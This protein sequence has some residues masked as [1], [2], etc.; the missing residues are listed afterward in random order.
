MSCQAS[1]EVIVAGS[2]EMPRLLSFQRGLSVAGLV[3]AAA[4]V[5]GGVV[6]IVDVSACE[7]FDVLKDSAVRQQRTQCVPFSAS[8]GLLI[9]RW[10]RSV[11]SCIHGQRQ[12]IA[13]GFSRILQSLQN[14]ASIIAF[15]AFFPGPEVSFTPEK[16]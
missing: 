1:R 10:C 6:V 15:W 11:I 16:A 9:S 12:G 8:N 2:C 5:F 14:S 3:L 7:L 13:S 4:V